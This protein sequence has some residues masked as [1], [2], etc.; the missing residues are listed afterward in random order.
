MISSQVQRTLVKSPPELW[1]ELSDPDAL[2]RALGELGEVRITHTEP[3]STVEWQA[4]R[5]SGS[6]HIKASGWGTRVTLRAIREPL[7]PPAASPPAVEEAEN[8]SASGEAIPTATTPSVAPAPADDGGLAESHSAEPSS[9]EPSSAEPQSHDL[10]SAE[11]QSLELQ[12]AEPPS[13]EP[14]SHDLQ[15][16]EP[17][18]AEPQSAEPP[19]VEAHAADR[20]GEVQA[21]EEPTTRRNLLARVLG[22]RRRK[23]D[24]MP[25]VDSGDP[26]IDV[27]QANWGDTEEPLMQA[28]MDPEPTRPQPQPTAVKALAGARPD[29]GTRQLA[30]EP[31]PKSRQGAPERGAETESKPPSPELETEA[32][33]SGAAGAIELA[34]ELRIAEETAAEQVHAVLT[35]ALDR[36]GAAHHRPFSRA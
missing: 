6:V 22:W 16:A 26:T 5:A 17:Q 33:P 36:L 31:E 8:A 15:S 1:A 32:E 18:S 30:I 19:S 29:D 24:H 35:S 27:E 7:P 13:V 4:E 2:A 3:E 14:Q 34:D 9:A 21:R 10:Q 25:A 12:S 28:S 11:P 20:R 23:R